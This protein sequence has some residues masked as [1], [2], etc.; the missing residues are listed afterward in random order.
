[1]KIITFITKLLFPS[2]CP[3]C[4]EVEEQLLTGDGVAQ[5]CP[6]REKKLVRVRQPFCL[7]CGKPL[8]EDRVHREYCADCT[9]QAHAFSQGRAVFVYQGDIIGSMHRLKYANRRDYAAIYAREAYRTYGGW[10]RRIAPDMIV[11][12]PLHPRRRRERGYN[13]A[14]LIAEALAELT[15]IPLRKK[16]ILRT[17]YT[18]PQKQLS[19]KERK[20]NLKNAFQ[21]SKKIVQLKKVLL[22]DDIYTTGSTVDAV[23]EALMS[24]GVKKI[25]VLCIC[26]GGGDGGGFD[27]GSKSLQNV[28]KIV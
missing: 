6:Q 15:G 21:M 2:S 25:Y 11:P 7:K 19:A 22:I 18:K 17:V 9:K 10:I 14:E 8:E 1:M 20:N 16:L 5:F 28:Q 23:S 24:A 26:I 12:V 3:I 4:G 13:Q 27:D